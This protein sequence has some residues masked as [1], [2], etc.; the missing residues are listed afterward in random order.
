MPVEQISAVPGTPPNFYE[1][2]CGSLGLKLRTRKKCH[3]VLQRPPNAF[4]WGLI[5]L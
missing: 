1:N 2:S 4:L 5:P 3:E